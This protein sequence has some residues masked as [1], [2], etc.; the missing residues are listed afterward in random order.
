[1]SLKSMKFR[2]PSL[3]ETSS[4]PSVDTVGPV[5]ESATGIVLLTANF[6]S[7]LRRIYQGVIWDF[8]AQALGRKSEYHVALSCALSDSGFANRQAEH[9]VSHARS[10]TV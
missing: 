7:Y 10:S 1:M 5:G 4:T 2:I 3:R 9:S 8:I 6:F